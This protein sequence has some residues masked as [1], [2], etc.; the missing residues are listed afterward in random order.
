MKRMMTISAAGAALALWATAA[1][2]IDVA[3]GDYTILPD[4][5]TV[6]LLYYQYSTSNHLTLPG[7]SNV[8]DSDLDV[9]VG[10]LRGLH[11]SEIGTYPVLFQA[12][13]PVG[14]FTTA[15]IGGVDQDR[16]AG[17]GDLTLGASFWPVSPSNPETGTTL[18]LTMFVT[19]P[20][21]NYD[22]T[23]VSIGGGAWVVTP[24]AGLIQGLG[25]G[26]YL[27]ATA[28]AA[29]SFDHDEGAATVSRKPSY[30]GQ[31]ALRKQFTPQTSISV[32]YSGQ[33][34]GALKVNGIETG[35]ETRR[36]QIRLYANTFLTP[37]LQLQGMIG[38]DLHV[39][40]GFKTGALAEIRLLKLF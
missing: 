37:S 40:G 36:D 31:I 23:G 22:L 15:R 18:G 33:F 26:F 20:T 9:S 2:A 13:L 5:T 27:D 16:F 17:L 38:H 21:G 34:G 39:E 8:P 28:D 1:A 12:V 25:S 35:L 3:P 4:G 30:Q 6:G 32:G 14:G 10:V 24:Q 19:A 11:Y 7:A 29:F